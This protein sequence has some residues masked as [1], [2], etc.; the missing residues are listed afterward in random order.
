[1]VKKNMLKMNIDIINQC[2]Y[3]TR[4]DWVF[5]FFSKKNAQLYLNV[6]S[7]QKLRKLL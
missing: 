1:M 3:I 6:I 5:Y 7:C 4:S 2:F